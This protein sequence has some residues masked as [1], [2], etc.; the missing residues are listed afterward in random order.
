MSTKE[1]IVV[2]LNKG[3]EKVGWMMIDEG[4]TLFI[5]VFEVKKWL[6]TIS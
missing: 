6:A 5:V 4:S 3:K 2:F 1:I